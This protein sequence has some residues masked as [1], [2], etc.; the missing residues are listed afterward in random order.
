MAAYVHV[1]LTKA[2]ARAIVA[3]MEMDMASG[4]EDMVEVFG[5]PA[6][7][8]ADNGTARIR[9]ALEKHESDREA[10]PA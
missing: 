6:V 10:V 5:A 9:K 3:V 4:Y 1:Q 8:A 7:G 2:Q